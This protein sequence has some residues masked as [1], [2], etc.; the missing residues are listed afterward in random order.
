MK[1]IKDL[2]ITKHLFKVCLALAAVP[3]I[4]GLSCLGTIHGKQLPASYFSNGNPS[5]LGLLNS[6]VFMG[7]IF[8]ITLSVFTYVA[9]LLWQLHEVAVHRA[10]ATASPQ[11]QLIFALSLCG[12]FIHK[13]WWV[14]AII[15]AFTSWDVIG[16]GLSSVIQKGIKEEK[17]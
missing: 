17:Q 14:L 5:I 16:Q 13:A 12:L 4:Y 10:E 8:L 1:K 15:I 9:Y 3:I 11:L 2:L 7:I 6:E